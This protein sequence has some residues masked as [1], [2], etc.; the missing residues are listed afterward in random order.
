[1]LEAVSRALGMAMVL[2]VLP[3]GYL[4]LFRGYR[5]ARYFV[6]AWSTLLFGIFINGLIFVDLVPINAFTVN[7]MPVGSLI[8]VVLLSLALA[9]R[10]NR[11]RQEKEEAQADF[12]RELR[13]LNQSLELQV[14]RRT[15]ELRQAKEEAEAAGLVLARKNREL[16]QMASHDMLTGL[17]NRRAFREQAELLLADGARYGYPVS[18]MM[19]DVDYFKSINDNYG[20]QLG[21]RVLADIGKLLRRDSRSSDRVARYGGEEFI[22]LL[23][24]ARVNDAMHKA[25]R[26]RRTVA[27]YRFE[28]Q[29][30]LTLSASFG[31]SSTDRETTGL[32]ELISR[33]DAAL[34]RAKHQGRN[35]V[36]LADCT[37]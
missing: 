28:E 8:E 24:H 29:D 20:H 13:S 31:V 14:A 3:A 9:D 6:L 18:L 33:A 26:L 34:Y 11:L 23:P 5:P 19:V 22:L 30:N 27:E 7:V 17:L 16:E 4:T 2:V 10:I 25:E 12:N 32:D 36:C 35:R 15:D 1:M 37:A 21:D